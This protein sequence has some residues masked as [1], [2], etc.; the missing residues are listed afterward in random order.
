M[1]CLPRLVIM[2][3]VLALATIF[4]ALLAACDS[5]LCHSVPFTIR[6][7]SIGPVWLNALNLSNKCT[8]FTGSMDEHALICP[9]CFMS[10]CGPLYCGDAFLL[11]CVSGRF[12]SRFI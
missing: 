6:Q 8:P 9:G 12:A 7:S 2:G 1:N 11:D 3:L 4:G 10:D 5:V